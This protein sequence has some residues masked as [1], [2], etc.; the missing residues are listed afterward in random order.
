MRA[1]VAL[2]LI[3]TA[4]ASEPRARPEAVAAPHASPAMLP[5]PRF[6]PCGAAGG[7]EPPAPVEELAL[8][9]ETS[10]ARLADGT[11][12]C[13][14]AR[15]HALVDADVI[16]AKACSV[17]T[18][19]APFEPSFGLFTVGDICSVRKDGAATCVD[20]HQHRGDF[21]VPSPQV[22]T[23]GDRVCALAKGQVVCTRADGSAIVLGKDVVQI[24]SGS[25]LWVLSK[26]GVLTRWSRGR[27][28]REPELDYLDPPA[29]VA[30][31]VAYGAR[32]CVRT[33]GPVS[34]VV[35]WTKD[36]FTNEVP[37]LND[38][39]RLAVEESHACAVRA[40]G[41]VVCWGS[42]G[43]GESGGDVPVGL[44]PHAS[45]RMPP[46]PITPIRWAR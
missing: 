26:G 10:C 17:A 19:V 21:T 40:T 1:A 3:A 12:W 44:C 37:G 33:R 18:R 34:K 14:G 2:A 15:S 11:V 6:T 5:P 46:L 9:Q 22:A 4:C 27:D 35:C 16:G 43:C 25:A 28:G 13:W 32:A 38:A 8:G 41:Q 39:V 24:A 45:A 31:V 29:D 36:N 7:V 42:N 23:L 30:E 20:L